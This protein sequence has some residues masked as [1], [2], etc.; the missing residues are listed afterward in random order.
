MA[1]KLNIS[2]AT[3]R[4][5]LQELEKSGTIER[6]PSKGA[7]ISTKTKQRKLRLALLFPE[8]DISLNVLDYANW[9]A[10]SEIQRGI[11]NACSVNNATLTF[12]HVP[13]NSDPKEYAQSLLHEYDGALFIGG[14]LR[15]LKTKLQELHFPYFTLSDDEYYRIDYDRTEICERA[16]KYLQ[17]CGCQNI[18]VLAGETTSV[19]FPEKL[20]SIRKHFKVL[21][22]KIIISGTSE[23]ECYEVLK[24]TLPEDVSKLPDA[25][26]CFTQVIPFALLRLAQERGWSVPEDFMIMGYANNLEIRPTTPTLTYVKIP[27]FEMGRKGTE[28]LIKSITNGTHIPLETNIKAELIIGKTTYNKPTTGEEK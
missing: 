24:K 20:E 4:L 2:R 1:D 11:I 5:A 12:Q 21:H 9:A 3:A 26:F 19:S 23:D 6:I 10:S 27:Y 28:I 16:A 17:T 13:V 18:N 25:F 8:T 15:C 7:F 22:S 14:Q